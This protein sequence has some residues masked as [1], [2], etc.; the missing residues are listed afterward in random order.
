MKRIKILLLSLIMLFNVDNIYALSSNTVDF[1]NKGSIQ[2]TLY[3]KNGN[4]KIKGSEL[5]IYK[6]AN[7]LEKDHN[8]AFEYVS[9]LNGCSASL[10]DLES[11]DISSEIE[12]CIPNNM[13]GITKETDENGNVK[14]EDLDLGLYLVKQTNKVEGFSKIDSFLI[15]TPKVIDNKWIYDIKATPKTDIIRVID[16]NV[17]KVWNTST[18]NTN[19]V[20]NIPENITVELLLDNKVIDT[21]ILSKENDWKYTWKD[22]EKSDMYTVKEIKVPKGYTATYE[23]IDNTVVITNT[24]TLVQTGNNN[25]LALIIGLFGVTFI[26]LGIFYNLKVKNEQGI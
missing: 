9:E 14:Y 4:E 26:M 11:A 15:M 3:E 16:I 17:K 5:T 6:V 13:N 7:A 24:K 21:I 1:N 23:N 25:Y 10:V 12:K 2:I 22:L 20:I 19:H 8:L 18:N